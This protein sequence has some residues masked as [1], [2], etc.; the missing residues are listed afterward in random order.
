V[1]VAMDGKAF[2]VFPSLDGAHFPAEVGGYLFQETSFLSGRG[3][4][5]GLGGTAFSGITWGV[6]L[7]RMS[8]RIIP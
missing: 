2:G 6:A 5:S 8:A 3:D 7:K 4:P 1:F